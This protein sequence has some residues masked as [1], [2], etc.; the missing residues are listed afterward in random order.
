MNYISDARGYP[1][2]VMRTIPDCA[3]FTPFTPFVA[4][5]LKGFAVAYA[6]AFRFETGFLISVSDSQ[7]YRQLGNAVVPAVIEQIGTSIMEVVSQY[8]FNA[9][10]AA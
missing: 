9:Q 7:A 5:R 6:S 4:R 8:G 1:Q 10:M 2:Y 3:T